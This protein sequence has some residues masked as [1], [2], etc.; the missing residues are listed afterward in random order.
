MKK[1]NLNK[2][3]DRTDVN[4]YISL[5]DQGAI[6]NPKTGK[7]LFP[8]KQYHGLCICP[9]KDKNYDVSKENVKSIV[10]TFENVKEALEE[11]D[12]EYFD[13]IGSNKQREVK[14]LHNEFLTSYIQALNQYC[15]YFQY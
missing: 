15:G 11:V 9:E 8:V 13:F 7:T 12:N 3:T 4:G 5:F 10:I 14:N 6:R 1:I 2:Y